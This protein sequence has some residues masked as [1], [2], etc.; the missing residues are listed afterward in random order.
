MAAKTV[1]AAVAVLAAVTAA[2]KAAAVTTT[3]SDVVVVDDP[4]ALDA[5]DDVVAV[6]DDDAAMAMFG[7][8]LERWRPPL[9]EPECRMHRL[10][11]LN[12]VLGV[13]ADSPVQ[14]PLLELD[15]ALARASGQGCSVL[16]GAAAKL[17]M[18]RVKLR[19]YYGLGE[20]DNVAAPVGSA[21]SLVSDPHFNRNRCLAVYAFGYTSFPNNIYTRDAITALVQ[22]N[23]YNVL[24]VDWSAA[25]NFS[26]ELS[27]DLIDHVASAVAQ[28]LK[29]MLDDGASL[30]FVSGHSLGGQMTGYISRHLKALGDTVPCVIALDP[31]APLF[32]GKYYGCAQRLARGDADRVIVL[33]SDICGLGSL[34]SQGDADFYPNSGYHGQPG[35]PGDHYDRLGTPIGSCSHVR[36]VSIFAAAVR[37]GM[38]FPARR[39][40]S[41]EDFNEGFCDD[42]GDGDS[43]V[44]FFPQ[45]SQRISGSFF[46][47]TTGSVPLQSTNPPAG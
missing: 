24:L 45:C 31:A 34:I 30:C 16:D 2:V 5:V 32:E 47:N 42:D 29:G 1:L 13:T 33:H 25:T 15:L 40:D 14:R 41:W 23:Q 46:M 35:C 7:R 20:N 44:L 43:P 38:A 22:A 17:V 21:S 10:G 6:D 3:E 26:Y 4:E 28:D 39:C 36:A 8:P 27:V 11:H 37:N 18:P 9:G 19:L 12:S